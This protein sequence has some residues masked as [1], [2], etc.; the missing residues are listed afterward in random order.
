MSA[1]ALALSSSS[2][3][4]AQD[5]PER[6]EGS[7]GEPETRASTRGPRAFLVAAA[8]LCSS[9]AP[10]L[11][12]LPTGA[13]LP[14]ADAADALRE[15]TRAC[16]AVMSITAEIAVSGSVGGHRLRVRLLAGLAAPASARLEAVA[17]FGQPVFIFVARNNDATLLLPRDRR[18]LEHGRPDAV[19][20]AVAGVPLDAADLRMA[21]TGCAAAP[22]A[23]DAK[24][25]GEDWRLVPDGSSD[26]YVHRASPTAPW[27]IVAA[28]HRGSGATSW[29][30]EYRDFQTA[31]PAAGLPSTVRLSSIDRKQF[32]LR[33]ALSQVELNV[34]LDADAF[35][36]QTPPGAEPITIDELKR[37]GPLSNTSSGQ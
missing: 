34:A 6:V 28:V 4:V 8:F 14:A 24:Q 5:N 21:L 33:L 20:E 22:R 35:R 23:S 1:R 10:P 18:V 29:R 16:Q 3:D 37:S 27:R 7:K 17:P 36:I 32:D 9:C 30:S 19:L 13:G 31:G 12:K 25:L 15:A 11:M 26:V 2:F